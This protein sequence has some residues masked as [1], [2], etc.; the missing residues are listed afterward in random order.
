MEPN[1]EKKTVT[2]LQED[3]EELIADSALPVSRKNWILLGFP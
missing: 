1:V 3:E 2:I